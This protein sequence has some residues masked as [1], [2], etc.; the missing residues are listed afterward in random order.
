MLEGVGGEAR[1]VVGIGLDVEEGPDAAVH[2][3]ALP[4]QED[5]E[6]TEG[7]TE[8]R[9]S[10]VAWKLM[11]KYFRKSSLAHDLSRNSATPKISTFC[12][13]L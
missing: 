11:E 2:V 8:R 10:E 7:A 4:L 6:L 5:A 13:T 9:A 12:V 1:H 3:L